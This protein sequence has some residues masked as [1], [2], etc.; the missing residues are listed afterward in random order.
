MVMIDDEMVNV[1]Y[2]LDG[3][4]AIGVGAMKLG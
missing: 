1:Y 4:Y 3:A 2:D